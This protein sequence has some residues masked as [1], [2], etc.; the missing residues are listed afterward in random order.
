MPPAWRASQN[1]DLAAKQTSAKEGPART[2]S[3]KDEGDHVQEDVE[4][5]GQEKKAGLK[6]SGKGAGK[7][8][9][10]DASRRTSKGGGKGEAKCELALLASVFWQRT[11]T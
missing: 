1:P 8:E 10:S 7:E 3:K 5:V 11:T 2:K 9:G 6:P 4:L